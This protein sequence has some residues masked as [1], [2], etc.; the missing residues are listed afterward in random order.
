LTPR[1]TVTSA[2]MR[3]LN[4]LTH[5][6]THSQTLQHVAY[7]ITKHSFIFDR[8]IDR[9]RCC[10]YSKLLIRRIFISKMQHCGISSY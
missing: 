5:S 6:L 2:L 8:Y 4:T 7:D 3:L 10:S 1:R 9:R